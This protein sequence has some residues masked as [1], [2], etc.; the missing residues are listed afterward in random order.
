LTAGAL[1]GERQRSLDAGMNDF[2]SKPFDPQ[3]LIRKV[4]RLVEQREANRFQWCSTTSKV[5]ARAAA[6]PS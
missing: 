1:V 2:V 4:R 5:S 6:A 3:V